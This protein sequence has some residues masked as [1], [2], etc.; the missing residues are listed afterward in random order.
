MEARSS[1]R[2]P[3]YRE[4]PSLPKLLT[5]TERAVGARGRSGIVTKTRSVV[6]GCGSYLP[7]R[8]LANDDLARTV[9]T[10]AECRM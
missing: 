6:L 7:T 10:S 3:G 2:F 1:A 8:I 4:G 9:D 5:H